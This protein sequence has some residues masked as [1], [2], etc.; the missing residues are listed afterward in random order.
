MVVWLLGSI[1]YAIVQ[2]DFNN[3]QAAPVASPAPAM[4]AA[5]AVNYDM[6][7]ATTPQQAP[8]SDY[9]QPVAVAAPAESQVA[10]TTPGPIAF[11][12]PTESIETATV[13]SEDVSMDDSS[14]ES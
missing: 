14:S 13:T 6:N 1:G 12:N 3:I 11:E 10:D 5:P 4:A 2:N 7:N 8:M 9:S